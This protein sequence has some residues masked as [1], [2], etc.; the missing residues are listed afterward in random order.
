MHTNVSWELLERLQVTA[1]RFQITVQL[2]IAAAPHGH[3]Y[4]DACRRSLGAGLAG[5]SG[6]ADPS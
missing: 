1:P 2:P 4:P 3:S 5:G 6:C